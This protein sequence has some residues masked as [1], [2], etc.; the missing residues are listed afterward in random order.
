MPCRLL[1]RYNISFFLTL[2]LVIYSFTRT[3]TIIVT[4]RHR[5]YSSL[6]SIHEIFYLVQVVGYKSVWLAPPS[7]SAL[8]RPFQHSQAGRIMDVD[9]LKMGNTSR[10]DVFSTD[11]DKE[12]SNLLDQVVPSSM[13]ATLSPGD[14]LFF[15]PGWWHAMRSETTS[16]SIS[17]W[18]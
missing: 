18:F 11:S 3:H 7:V 14:M 16:F 5:N 10:L 15:P 8:M 13:T 9:E 12:C 6:R 4:V 17:M 2:L 1:I